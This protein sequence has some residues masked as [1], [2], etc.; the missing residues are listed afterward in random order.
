MPHVAYELQE[1]KQ[2]DSSQSTVTVVINAASTI[3]FN[4]VV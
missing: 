2:N 3:I 4:H 1:L